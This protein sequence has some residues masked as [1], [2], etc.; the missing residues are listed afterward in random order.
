MF[1]LQLG[2]VIM[3]ALTEDLVSGFARIHEVHVCFLSE[4]V[5]HDQ[6]GHSSAEII[7]CVP[8]CMKT[9]INILIITF[10]PHCSNVEGIGV[11]WM[12]LV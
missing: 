9:E 6:F 1:N 3:R 5:M 12:L 7:K 10:G 8:I 11:L 4:M 2:I